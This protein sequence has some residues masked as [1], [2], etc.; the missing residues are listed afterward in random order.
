MYLK[1]LRSKGIYLG[2][3]LLSHN[4]SP[5]VFILFY[6]IKDVFIYHT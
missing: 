1:G 6:F 2:E 3:N 5:L 4:Y